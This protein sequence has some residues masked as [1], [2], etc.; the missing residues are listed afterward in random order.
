M[1]P[2]PGLRDKTVKTAHLPK[3]SL[4]TDVILLQFVVAF[5]LFP[6]YDTIIFER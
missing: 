6:L 1:H 4:T 2:K 5:S 3:E